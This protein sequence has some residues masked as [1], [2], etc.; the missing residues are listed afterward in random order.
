MIMRAATG[1][2]VGFTSNQAER[3]ARPVK[4]RQRTSGGC[5]RTLDALT[6]L[7]TYGPWLPTAIRTG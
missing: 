3:D 1:L 2:A 4:V 7:F 5:S 6:Q